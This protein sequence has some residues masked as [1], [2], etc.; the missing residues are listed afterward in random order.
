MVSQALVSSRRA[1]CFGGAMMSQQGEAT[2]GYGAREVFF[3][4][5][6]IYTGS[7][8]DLCCLGCSSVAGNRS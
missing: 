7:L 3:I 4:K 1:E 5:L 6:D 2:L 8:G